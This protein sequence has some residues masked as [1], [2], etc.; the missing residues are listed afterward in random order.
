[1]RRLQFAREA[2]ED[3]RD[4]RVQET[5]R[6]VVS[7]LRDHPLTKQGWNTVTATFTAGQ[8]KALDHKLGRQPIG[9]IATDVVTGDGAFRRTAWDTRTISLRAAN[10]C[11]ATFLVF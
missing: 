6:D 3:V 2:V 11:T 4:A 7:L 9:W 8:T 1:M 5:V 10:A